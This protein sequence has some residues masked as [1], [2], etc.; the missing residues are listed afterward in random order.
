MVGGLTV[1]AGQ[2]NCCRF[3]FCFFLVQG[4][5]VWDGKERVWPWHVGARGVQRRNWRGL[6]PVALAPT[7]SNL[8]QTVPNVF[9]RLWLGW[10][11]VGRACPA[12]RWIVL[13]V[14]GIKR[15]LFQW[16]EESDGEEER[17]RERARDGGME[18]EEEERE[19]GV[20]TGEK[21]GFYDVCTN[22]CTNKCGD[23]SQSGYVM[24]R[25]KHV[26]VKYKMRL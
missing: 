2:G 8:E 14:P 20:A 9:I 15:H 18:E 6:L 16:A 4:V 22:L 19:W 26:A 5:K 23:S 3:V 10:A 12:W 11:Q 17:G 24:S 13:I 1:Q 25:I 7:G 21:S